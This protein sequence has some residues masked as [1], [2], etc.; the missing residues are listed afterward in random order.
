MLVY[1]KQGN[2]LRKPTRRSLKSSTLLTIKLA[3]KGLTTLIHLRL[4]WSHN[5][6]FTRQF[7]VKLGEPQVNLSDTPSP[8]TKKALR[9]RI[10]A[11]RLQTPQGSRAQSGG[12]WAPRPHRLALHPICTRYYLYDQRHA[13]SLLCA[14]VSPRVK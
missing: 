10:A 8:P 13:S 7:H 11:H 2:I 5:A 12:W 4:L 6:M 14:S 3:T 9:K 1:G